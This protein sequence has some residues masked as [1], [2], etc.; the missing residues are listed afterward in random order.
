MCC[1]D[2]FKANDGK[3]RSN[4]CPAFNPAPEWA[5]DTRG[6]NIVTTTARHCGSETGEDHSQEVA[7]DTCENSHVGICRDTKCYP[8]R[9]KRIEG[10]SPAYCRSYEGG[11]VEE[12][13]V[14]HTDIAHQP[15]C[16]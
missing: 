2:D 11:D 6:E 16:L 1:N 3:S 8:F 7:G 9:V 15:R 5:D 10:Y 14:S 4:E 13:R 12:E